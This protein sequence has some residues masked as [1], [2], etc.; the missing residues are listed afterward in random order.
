MIKRRVGG[1]NRLI[2][3]VCALVKEPGDVNTAIGSN[4]DFLGYW[5]D[6]LDAELCACRDRKGCEERTSDVL[7]KAKGLKCCL[8][9]GKFARSNGVAVSVHFRQPEVQGIGLLG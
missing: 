1:G 7:V 4:N 6:H 2:S 3:A 8:Y 5:R 9:V